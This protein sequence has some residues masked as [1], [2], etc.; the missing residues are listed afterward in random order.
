V[1]NQRPISRRVLGDTEIR[2]MFYG[3]NRQLCQST[4]VM[5]QRK[6]MSQ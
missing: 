4:Q 6:N 2:G 3:G 5:V 1:I